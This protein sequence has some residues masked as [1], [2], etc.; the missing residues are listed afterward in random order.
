MSLFEVTRREILYFKAEAVLY[1]IADIV[2]TLKRKI[3]LNTLRRDLRGLIKSLSY[4]Q[5]M[6]ITEEK[7][8]IWLIEWQILSILPEIERLEK[9][10]GYLRKMAQ[11]EKDKKAGKPVEEIASF[12]IEGLKT[13]NILEIA[14]SFGLVPELSGHKRAFV[15]LRNERT[16][17]CCLY[18]DRNSWYDFGSGEHGDV[19]D[20]VGKLDNC[21]FKNACKRLIYMGY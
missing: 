20:L 21:D 3:N 16:P 6:H 9:R 15:K 19:I 8:N 5:H 11:I 4:W 18:L 14:R 12:D 7:G 1:K 17:S 10:I 13:A 2:S